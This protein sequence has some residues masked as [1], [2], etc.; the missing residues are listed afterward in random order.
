MDCNMKRA[1]TYIYSTKGRI[2]YHPTQT[3]STFDPDTFPFAAQGNDGVDNP[4]HPMT[5]A[6]LPSNWM[7]RQVTQSIKL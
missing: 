6:G 4:D 2:A 7:P 1:M 5:A 3:D